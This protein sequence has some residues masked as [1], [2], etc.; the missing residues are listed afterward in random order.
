MNLSEDTLLLSTKLKIPAPRKNYIIRKALFEKLSRCHDTSVTFLC[1]GAGTGKTT[2]L[3]SF[4]QETH[5]H[6]VAWISLDSANTDLYSFWLYFTAAISTGW[7]DGADY[8]DLIRSNPGSIHVEHILTMLVNRLCDGVRHYIVLDDVHWIKNEALIQSLDFFIGA[9]PSNVHLFML[10]REE[11]PVYLGSLAVSGMLQYIDGRQMQLTEEESLLF[12][13]QTLGMEENEAQLNRLSDYAEGWI[14]GLQ[15]AAAIGSENISARML[16]AGGGIAAEYLTREIIRMLPSESQFFLIRTSFLSYFHAAICSDL[17]ENFSSSDFEQMMLSLMQKNLFIICLDEKNGIYRYHNIL[18]DY[19]EQLFCQLP[20]AEQDSLYR[21][22]AGYLEQ[23]GDYEEALRLYSINGCFSEVL[24]LARSFS[25][26]IRVWKYLNEVP[27]ELLMK[28]PDLAAQCF[29]YNLGNINMDRCRVLYRQFEL[30]YGE[31]ELFQIF[32]FLENS[33]YQDRGVLPR[34]QAMQI[35][36]INAL[37]LG[38]VTKAMVFVENTVALTDQMKY[39]EAEKCIHLAEE[40][41]HGQNILVDFF[42]SNQ[43]AQIYEETGNLSQSLL[44]YEHSRQ[45]LKSPSLMIGIG[46]NYYFGLVGVYMRRMELSEATRTL[47]EAEELMHQH[48]IHEEIIDATLYFHQSEMHFLSGNE[49]SGADCVRLFHSRFSHYST[50]SMSRLLYELSCCDRLPTDM[51]DRFLAELALEDSYKRQ[52]FMILLKSRILWQ[53][54][55]LSSLK[56]IDDIL[57]LSRMQHNKL[58]LTEAALLKAVIL[59]QM[60]EQTDEPEFKKEIQNLLLESI[61]YAWK[62]RILMPFYL[63]RRM[64]LPL[65]QTLSRQESEKNTLPKS[66]A[67]F[68]QDILLCCRPSTITT[69]S[70]Y[71]ISAREL[72]VLG[73][74]DKGLT[75]REIADKLCISQATVKT[76]LLSIFN[77]LGVSS[78]LL[79]VRA[80]HETGLLSERES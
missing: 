29:L 56:E 2:L 26:Q 55:E 62:D 72:E 15:L 68:L 17:F 71:G 39:P 75:N 6:P 44:C 59:S 77:K 64:L 49:E 36:Q 33:V 7:E 41:N 52:P 37:P 70:D 46:T 9:M 16:Q 79:A 38:D 58:H 25:G 5:L 4:I 30:H 24:R 32:Q 28:D 8:L 73:E 47:E 60:D 23:S 43:H 21:K 27:D 10:S 42:A 40:L 18:S 14:G 22:A 45:L 65:L 78:R 61:H 12:M 76:H 51:A 67:D 63:E 34:Y 57:V 19:L 80:G 20:P 35:E 54:G 74:L 53:N 66:E 11:P 1:G 3:S 50:L 13:T 69:I 31:T 48:Q